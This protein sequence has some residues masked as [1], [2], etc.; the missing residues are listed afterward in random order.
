MARSGGTVYGK[1]VSYLLEVSHIFS[2][3]ESHFGD[4]PSGGIYDKSSS[5]VCET[6]VLVMLSNVLQK[7]TAVTSV[8]LC[9]KDYRLFLPIVIV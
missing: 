1:C 8:F 3:R 7:C 2:T 4:F 6:M 9:G 5:E